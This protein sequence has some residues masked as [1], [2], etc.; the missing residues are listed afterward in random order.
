MTDDQAETTELLREIRDN[1]R[2][3]LQRQAEA[4]EMQRSQFEMARAQIDR[5]ERLQGRAEALQG[6][7]GK[8]LK[9]I[10]WLALPLLALLLFLMLRSYV[11]Y[12]S[13]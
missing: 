8:A 6:K 10:L 7:A 11:P 2:I 3:Q 12:L 9:F 5:A 13:L 1:Q 4:L